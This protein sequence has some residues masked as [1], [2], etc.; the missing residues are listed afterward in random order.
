MKM[1]KILLFG[2]ITASI[3]SSCGTSSRGELVGVQELTEFYPS[4]PYGMVHIPKGTFTMGANDGDV[5]YAHT[6]P[7]KMVTMHSFFMDQT[8][9][10]NNEYRQFVHWVRDS[11]ARTLLAE[12]MIE[13]YEYIEETPDGEFL[14]NP[15][16][17]W[18]VDI[19]WSNDNEEIAIAL[20]E[21]YYSPEE[22]IMGLKEYD[23]RSW[24]YKYV[25]VDKTAAAS[26][27]NRFDAETGTYREGYSRQDLVF[28]DEVLVY[29]DTMVWMRDFSYTFNEP[30]F[31]SYFWHPGYGEYPVVGVNWDQANAFCN[32]RTELRQKELTS[33][34]IQ[35]ETK[36]RLPTEVEWEYAARGNKEH[37]IYPWGGPYSRN[38]KGC[39]LAN[40]KP[41]RGNYIADGYA[42]TA[43]SIS[44][45]ANDYGLYNMSGNVSEWTSTPFEPTASM[46]VSDMNPFY[47]YDADDS[48]HPMLKRKVIKGGSWKDVGVFL[49]VASKDYEYQDT[50]KSYIGFRC[51]KT[52]SGIEKVDFGY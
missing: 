11:I 31:D 26:S 1:R 35:Y 50:S 21:M 40:F 49:Q 2:V 46:F 3:F 20:E 38:S 47:T 16:L 12:S 13:G 5:P 28:E 24:S 43:P 34:Q 4:D 52:Y 19:D 30:M 29:P 45:W 41:V 27:L 6:T 22:Q 36:F 33:Y 10:T 15:Y 18:D 14:D 17:N 44:Y 7:K 39:F 32:W 51:V 25:W 48:N 8:E 42:Y 9:I 23:S 37:S